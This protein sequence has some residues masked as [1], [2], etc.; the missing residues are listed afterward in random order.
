MVSCLRLT[1]WLVC[2]AGVGQSW[3]LCGKEAVACRRAMGMLLPSKDDAINEVFV[4]AG[5]LILDD[6]S[7]VHVGSENGPAGQGWRHTVTPPRNQKRS[8]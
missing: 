3:R 4:T 7:V 5:M 8:N 2:A 1:L 6:E